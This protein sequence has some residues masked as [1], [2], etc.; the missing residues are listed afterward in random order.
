MN[1]FV[2]L[3]KKGIKNKLPFERH[4]QQYR[5]VAHMIAKFGTIEDLQ[6]LDDYYEKEQ[7][8]LRN[9]TDQAIEYEIS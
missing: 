7:E 6:S 8:E 1:N 5:I 2:R 4:E 3:Y 9:E